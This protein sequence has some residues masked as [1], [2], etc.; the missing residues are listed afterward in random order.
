VGVE[1]TSTWD[2]ALYLAGSDRY[3]DVILP[4]GSFAG[5]PEEA[6]NCACSLYL[7]MPEV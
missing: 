6:L 3:E 2:F 4:T 5:S 1:P 7:A